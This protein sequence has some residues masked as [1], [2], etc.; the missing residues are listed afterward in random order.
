MFGIIFRG[1]SVFREIDF[2]QIRNRELQ[3]YFSHNQNP[4]NTKQKRFEQPFK[5]S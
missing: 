4:N 1:E 5:F 3:M 2:Y